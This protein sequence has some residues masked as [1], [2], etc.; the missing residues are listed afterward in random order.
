MIMA[1]RDQQDSGVVIIFCTFQVFH[2]NHQ[3]YKRNSIFA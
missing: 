3:L 2:F 1:D